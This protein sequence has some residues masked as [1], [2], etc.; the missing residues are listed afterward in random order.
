MKFKNV[1][2]AMAFVFAIGLSFATERTTADPQWDYV[3]M[4]HRIQKIAE[5]SCENKTEECTGRFE[6]GGTLYQIFD[7]PGLT[8]PKLGAEIVDE[9]LIPV[10]E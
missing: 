4:G 8:N 3:N 2:L 7:G 10:V 1:F 9:L 5:V 6:E